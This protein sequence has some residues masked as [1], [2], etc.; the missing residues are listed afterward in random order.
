[1]E[2]HSKKEM[3]DL[4][5]Q[6]LTG[7]EGK[8]CERINIERSLRGK[9][10][11]NVTPEYVFTEAGV[12]WLLGFT[13]SEKASGRENYKK[14]LVTCFSMGWFDF[15]VGRTE[16]EELLYMFLCDLLLYDRFM[17]GDV[18]DRFIGKHPKSD[19]ARKLVRTAYAT[20]ATSLGLDELV[21]LKNEFT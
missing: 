19:I 12:G 1:M 8:S 5:S 3:C 16:T 14:A 11:I 6:L 7:C 10:E 15:L 9:R 20:G 17:Y 18:A 2:I 4:V 21:K 13:F